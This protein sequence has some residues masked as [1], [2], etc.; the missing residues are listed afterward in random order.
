MLYPH[1]TDEEGEAQT[2]DMASLRSRAKDEG[3][4]LEPAIA[5]RHGFQ[6]IGSKSTQGRNNQ[7][8][9]TVMKLSSGG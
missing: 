6:S 3:A 5:Q 9:I 1:F 2:H 7:R 4:R 8:I